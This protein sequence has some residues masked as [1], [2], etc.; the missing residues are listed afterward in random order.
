VTNTASPP[1]GSI[2][3]KNGSEL[4]SALPMMTCWFVLLMFSI[5]NRARCPRAFRRGS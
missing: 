5:V 2:T 3:V 4:I 1:N